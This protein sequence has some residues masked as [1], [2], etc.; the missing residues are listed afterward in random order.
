MAVKAR[1][2]GSDKN[3]QNGAGQDVEASAVEEKRG[4]EIGLL[5]QKTFEQQALPSQL[6]PR[7]W[8]IKHPGKDL[9]QQ[10]NALPKNPCP[11]SAFFA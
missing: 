7:K 6:N 11:S 8:F 10:N 4:R 2:E 9:N 5:G 1:G 3:V